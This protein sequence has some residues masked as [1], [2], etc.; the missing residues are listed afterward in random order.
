MARLLVLIKDA[1]FLAPTWPLET[2]GEASNNPS[3]SDMF[4]RFLRN[5]IPSQAVNTMV[6][7]V[8]LPVYPPDCS[9]F[10]LLGE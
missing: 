2:C 5:P 10:L 4:G 6:A 3:V 7:D 9:S 1:R 8:T